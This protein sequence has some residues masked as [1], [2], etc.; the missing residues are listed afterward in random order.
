MF[1]GIIEEIGIISKTKNRANSMEIEI[2]C[3]KILEDV[4]IGDSI[5][6][7]GICLT[8]TTFDSSCF[9]THIMHETLNRSAIST[10]AVNT[11]VNLERAMSAKDRFGGHIVSGHIDGIGKI[12]NIKKDGISIWYTIATSDKILKYII[13]KG[14]IAIDGVSLT[15]AA[16]SHNSF[17]VSIIPHTAENTILFKKRIGDLVNLEN[18]CIGKYVENFLSADFMHKENKST[19]T[20]EFLFYNGF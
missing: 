12:S 11:Q 8:V 2:C 5:S 10:M 18:D 9:T 6:V 3:S 4:C 15:V 16:L 1:T 13:E 20:K 7:N 17:S 14:S 19:I